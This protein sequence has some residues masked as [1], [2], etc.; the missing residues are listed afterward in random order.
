VT[1]PQPD[2]RIDD[3]AEAWA[4]A[5]V[6]ASAAVLTMVALDVGGPVRSVGVLAFLLFVPGI[7]A[8][9]TAGYTG[10]AAM[11]SL[12]LV[13]SIGL[14]GTVAMALYAARRYDDL[15]AVTIVVAVTI[16]LVLVERL[17]APSRSLTHLAPPAEDVGGASTQR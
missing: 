6:G 8:I 9:R 10:T 4:A 3:D 15:L 7:A 1:E 14:D 12:S 17:L 13:L 2:P 11:L 16:L 5:I